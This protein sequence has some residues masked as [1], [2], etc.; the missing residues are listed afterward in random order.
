MEETV[1][2]VV[3]RELFVIVEVFPDMNEE[4]VS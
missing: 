2:L 1:S 4:S 3:E